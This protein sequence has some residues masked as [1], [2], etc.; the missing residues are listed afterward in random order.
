LVISKQ[1]EADG[2]VLQ[3]AMDETSDVAD[4]ELFVSREGLTM[5]GFGV[6]GDSRCRDLGELS[7]VHFSG[8]VGPMAGPESSS[9]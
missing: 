7:T 3:I 2:C 9:R 8:K 1:T 6:L 4:V 5:D